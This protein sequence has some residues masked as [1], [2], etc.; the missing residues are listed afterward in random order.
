MGDGTVVGPFFWNGNLDGLDYLNMINQHIVPILVAKYGMRQNGRIPT[1][2]WVQDGAPAHRRVEVRDRLQAL[3]GNR[4]IG[5]GHAREWPARSPDLTPLDFF[6][7]GYVKSKVYETVPADLNDLRQKIVHVINGLQR[8]RMV[9]RSFD[10]M[11]RRARLCVQLQGA[12][13][14]GR[15]AH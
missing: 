13:V 5:I 3:F 8:N 9:R 14:E 1:V 10:G 12:H 2:T 7:W 6:L 4:V 11:R 15:D